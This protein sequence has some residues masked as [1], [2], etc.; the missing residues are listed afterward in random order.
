MRM[1]NDV[2]EAGEAPSDRIAASTTG[3]GGMVI[4]GTSVMAVVHPTAAPPT[5][6]IGQRAA[7]KGQGRAPRKCAL[8]S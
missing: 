1:G 2:T 3:G 5:Q 7:D 6:K 8:C 4:A